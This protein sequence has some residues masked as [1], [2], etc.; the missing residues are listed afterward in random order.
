MDSKLMRASLETSEIE[1]VCSFTDS[2]P[3]SEETLV[4]DGDTLYFNAYDPAPDMDKA[5]GI[6]YSNGEGYAYLCSVD[7]NSGEYTNYGVICCEEDYDG[8][9][10][11]RV[12]MIGADNGRIY[13]DYQF[14]KDETGSFTHYNF[15]FDLES[16]EYS[17]GQLPAGIC[18]DKGVYVRLDD[19]DDELHVVTNGKD[20][21]ISYVNYSNSGTVFNNKLF[22]AGNWIDL[23]D[24]TMH[25]LAA[26]KSV[27][28]Y[29]NGSY[30]TNE[31][32]RFEKL[33]EEE[34]LALD[35]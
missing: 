29:Y 13:M 34:L 11:A 17:R 15:E 24:M 28:A 27:V 35:N 5:G 10:S 2:I 23:S 25:R 16:K 21:V 14:T 20:N 32:N 30:I 33:T 12:Y 4:I 3:H 7:L 8:R 1:L 18:A 22:V 6:S 26:N 31:N 9:K 19:A